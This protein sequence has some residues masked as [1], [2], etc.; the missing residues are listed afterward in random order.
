MLEALIDL[1]EAQIAAAQARAENLDSQALGL[2]GF[3]AAL[4]TADL[5]AQRLLG[6]SWWVPLP[7][8]AISI[9]LGPSR[10]A[11][12]DGRLRCRRHRCLE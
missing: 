12:A 1:T 11:F 6:H 4:V 5:A 7:G 2:V 9:V 8:L 3:A 10:H